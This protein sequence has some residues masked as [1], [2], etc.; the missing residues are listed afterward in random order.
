[1][2]IL[3]DDSGPFSWTSPGI[4]LFCGLTVADRDKDALE[5]RWLRWKRSIVG[6]SKAELKGA[7]L[8]DK[9]LESFSYKVFPLNNKNHWLTFVGADTRITKLANAR[10][11]G[12]QTADT[13]AACSRIMR[14]KYN[15]KKL[16]QG[17]LEMSGWLR[18][19]SPENIMWLF[20][21]S[22]AICD[23]LQHSIAR[24]LE[25][26]DDPEFDNI[27]ISIDKSFIR[28][29]AHIIFWQQ[30]LAQRM[31][32]AAAIIAFPRE[33][34]RRAH[35][36]N[37]YSKN[38]IC[39]MTPIFRDHMAFR[40][41]HQHIGLQIVDICANIGL[42]YFRGNRDLVAFRNLRPRV[43]GRGGRLITLI[44]I[45]DSAFYS[46]SPENHVREFDI[47]EFKARGQA[48]IQAMRAAYND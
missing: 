27:E 25:P 48:V 5:D 26:E 37:R 10:R 35:P 31:R 44:N 16:A 34:R 36:F 15:N 33:W 22:G 45:T 24:F 43:V 23:C 38:G 9:Q 32:N 29:D 3:V 13:L 4:S 18:R 30:W 40:E 28:R 47:D 46:D 11:F 8:T 2:R 20:C 17:Y 41:S 14:E 12:E 6:K 39:D 19:R 7:S 1:M 42:R 21:L